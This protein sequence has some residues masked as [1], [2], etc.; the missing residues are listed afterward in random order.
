MAGHIVEL[1][2]DHPGFHD[3]VYRQ[4]RDE[5]ARLAPPLDSASPPALVEY[6]GTEVTTWSTA[7][8]RLSSSIRPTPAGSSWR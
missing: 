6:T 4:R 2:A 8:D 5:I 1:D 7:F 3:P